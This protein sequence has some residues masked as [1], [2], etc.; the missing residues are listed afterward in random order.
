VVEEDNE[1]THQEI[2]MDHR[3]KPEAGDVR[4]AGCAIRGG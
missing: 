1:D 2:T 3:R 4:Q